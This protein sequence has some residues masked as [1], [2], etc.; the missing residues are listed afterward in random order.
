MI[1]HGARRFQRSFPTESFS[2]E[3][4]EKK[5]LNAIQSLY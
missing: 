4:D 5:A 2:H 1:F 3:K